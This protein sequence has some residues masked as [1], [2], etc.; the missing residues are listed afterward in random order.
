MNKRIKRLFAPNMRLY[1]LILVVFAAV[2]FIFK[3]HAKT[4]AV[5]ELIAVIVL[6]IYSRYNTRRRNGEI[7]SYI[8]SLTYNVDSAA[9]DNLVNFP[10]PMVI[11]SLENEEI[12]TANDSF[13]KMTGEGEHFFQ[14]HLSDIVPDFKTKWLIEGKDEAPEN[15]LLKDRLYRVFGNV[16]RVSQGGDKHGLLAT[17]YWLDVTDETHMQE[18]YIASRPVFAIIMLDNYD[19]LLNGLAEKD[20]SAILS[21]ID[22]RISDWAGNCGGYLSKYDRDRYIFM[23]ED[24]FLPGFTR[25]R[26]SLLDSV[27]EVLNPRGVSATVSIGVGKDGATLFE[28]YRFAS[29]S[30]DMALSRGGDQAVIKNRFNFEFYGGKTAQLEKRTKVKSRVMANSLS[31]LMSAASHIFIMGH[32][33]ADLDS[34]GAA[35]GICCAARKLG[36]KASIVLDLEHNLSKELVARIYRVPEYDGVFIT[37]EDAM[38]EADGASLLIVVDTNRPEQVESET[39]LLSCNRIA[40]IDHHRRAST[41]IQD[42]ALSFHEPYASSTSELVTELLQ[43]I[44]D[45]SDILR[46]EAEA[47]LAGIV[48]DTK[49]FTLCTG[50]RTFDAAAFLRRAGADTAEVKKFLQTDIKTAVRRYAIIQKARV[51]KAGIAVAAPETEETRV[52]AAQ[53]ADEML[54][55]LG[56]QASFVVFPEGEGV[57]ISAR[58]I[59][60]INVQVIVEKLGGGGNRSTA[61]AQISGKAQKDVVSDLL[62]AIDD[63]LA[64]PEEKK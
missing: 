59:G 43:Y 60:D 63:Y 31:E 45:P 5:I 56:I 37:P 14:V 42:A 11:F 40:V 58:S 46:C 47:L 44:A 23:F 6:L 34:V 62:G 4:V 22:D 61:G 51:Y 39:L 50:G 30:I 41:Y 57:T 48:L 64:D 36:K 26:F 20:K 24:R 17:T 1:F 3:E 25:A 49:N 28:N 18:E 19:E 8:E 29:L 55:L 9:K 16:V 53:A 13:L 52:I 38:L 21:M 32:K 7:L 2:T 54:N 15:I 33:L 27:R 10:M 35:V 12:V